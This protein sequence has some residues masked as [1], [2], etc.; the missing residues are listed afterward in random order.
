MTEGVYVMLWII[1]I[2]AYFIGGVFMLSGVDYLV[3]QYKKAPH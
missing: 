3:E 2:I 1:G